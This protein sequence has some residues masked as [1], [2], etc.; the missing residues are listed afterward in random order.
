[1]APIT[2]A[3]SEVPSLLEQVITALGMGHADIDLV[4]ALF[5]IRKEKQTLLSFI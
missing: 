4:S 5:S 1:M 3:L 2:A